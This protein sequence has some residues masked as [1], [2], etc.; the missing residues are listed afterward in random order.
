MEDEGLKPRVNG[1]MLA[2]F[3]G[4]NVCLL[5]LVANVDR[6]G[7][8]FQLTAGDHQTVVVK[9]QEPLQELVQG[10]VEVV[11]SVTGK[12]EV[13][14]SNFVQFPDEMSNGFDLDA[15]NKAV[16]LTQKFKEKSLMT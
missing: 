4:K 11:G 13:M 14:C 2:S 1:S 16:T 7:F 9:L 3:I 5:G 8:S 12:N 15:Y 10:L 6:S